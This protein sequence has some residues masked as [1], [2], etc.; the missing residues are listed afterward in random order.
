LALIL[1]FPVLIEY[2]KTG[3]VPR[4]PTLIVSGFIAL[5]AMMLWVGGVI[6]EVLSRN[7]WKQYELTLMHNK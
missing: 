6:L 3:L 5:F 1:V 7:H 2:F 4:F